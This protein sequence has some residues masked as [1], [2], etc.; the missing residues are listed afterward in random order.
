MPTAS[1]SDLLEWQLLRGRPAPIGL[2][3]PSRSGGVWSEHDYRNW[4]RRIFAPAAT[5]A[6]VTGTRPYDLRHSFASLLL[7]QGRSVIDVAD[8][9]GHAPTLTLDVY[10]HFMRELEGRTQSP[11]EVIAA[12]RRTRTA[13]AG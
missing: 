4:R 8:Q 9:L 10:G 5:A 13:D 7:A 2:V 6:G 3:F 12:A 1:R 11:D